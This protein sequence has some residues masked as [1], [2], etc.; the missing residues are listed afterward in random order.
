MQE[1]D[2]TEKWV[3]KAQDQYK[4]ERYEES[5]V[6]ANQAIALSPFVSIV[7]ME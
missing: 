5:I 6:S 1:T 3:D 4:R 2:T 7:L